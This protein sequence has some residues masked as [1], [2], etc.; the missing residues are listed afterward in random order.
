MS[1][2]IP[3]SVVGATG[4]VGQRLVA[5][6]AGHPWFDL[7][8]LA[9]SERSVGHTYGE[10]CRWLLDTPLPAVAASKVVRQ[11]LGVE[12][13]LVLSALDSAS[14]ARIEPELAR[15]GH[16]VASNASALRMDADVPLL[17]PEVNWDH[18]ALC[19]LQRRRWPGL[20]V[21][22]PNCVATALSLALAPLAGSFGL[23]SA[24]ITTMQAASGAGYPG[25]PSLDLMGNIIPD[26]DGEAEKI[27]SELIRLLGSLRDGDVAPHHACFTAATTRVPVLDGHTAVVFARLSREVEAEQLVQAWREF[28]GRPQELRLPTAPTSP[29]VVVDQPHRPQPRRDAMEGNGMSVVVSAPRRCRSGVWKFVVLGHNTVRGAAG[30]ALLNL[31]SLLA[32]GLLE[33]RAG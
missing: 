25:V 13:R 32:A 12:T 10:A 11:A 14:A 29:V 31:E 17:V 16:V 28:A 33:T 21:T 18:L 20:V 6:L 7:A 23:E 2:R 19:A 27:E 9:G 1:T 4:V 3:V 30:A 22:N 24:C 8:D 15:N 26:I 5:M